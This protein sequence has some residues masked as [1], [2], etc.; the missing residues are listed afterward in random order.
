VGKET[1]GREPNRVL[2][3]GKRRGTCPGGKTHLSEGK[4]EYSLT[5]GKKERLREH[6][7]SQEKR[8]TRRKAKEAFW[9]SFG[10]SYSPE[11]QEKKRNQLEEDFLAKSDEGTASLPA[12]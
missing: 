3:Y 2:R 8:F 10:S 12:S 1:G 9:F 7:K 5:V 6:G 4:K 11:R